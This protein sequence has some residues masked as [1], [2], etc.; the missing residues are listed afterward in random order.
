MASNRISGRGGTTA[1]RRWGLH[2]LGLLAVTGVINGSTSASIA[3]AAG[4]DP[5]GHPLF[6]HLRIGQGD[7]P[8]RVVA[9]D[10]DGD[11]QFD[12]VVTNL[13]TDDVSVFISTGNF[14]FQP[15]VRYPTGDGPRAIAPA[16]LNGDS[17]VDVFDLLD[18]LGA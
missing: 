16:D 8:R 12:L 2:A 18:L 13:L 5:C 9:G 11:S 3:W 7:L 14:T 1:Q 10:L 17:T 6:E 4:G 15:A